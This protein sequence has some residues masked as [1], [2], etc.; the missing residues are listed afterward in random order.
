MNVGFQASDGGTYPMTWGQKAIWKPVKWYGDASSFFNIPVAIDLPGDP[1]PGRDA[2]VAALRTLVERHQ[3]LRS[4][5]FDGPDGPA[6]QIERSGTF[7]IQLA[8]STPAGSR[9]RA[10]ALAT[11]LAAPC[12]DFK[13]E[14]SLRTALVSVDG[15]P[16]H[17]VFVVSHVA[18]D[19]GGFMALV[20]DFLALLG[21][22]PGGTSSEPPGERPA[23][24]SK[25]WQPADQVLSEQSK[26]GVRRSGAAVDYWRK[27]LTRIPPS[28]FGSEGGPAAEPRWHRLRMDSPAMAAAAIRVA[29]DCQISL[30]SAVLTGTALALATLTSQDITVMQLIVS[31]RY[32]DQMRSMVG[33]AAQDGLLVVDYPDV[34]LAEAARA[35]HRAARTGYFYGYYDPPAVDELRDR[36]AA[37]R[38]VQFDLTSYFNDLTPLIGAPTELPDP[39]PTEAEA[40]ELLAQTTIVTEATFGTQDCK[41]F[42]EAECGPAISRVHLLIDTAYVPPPLAETVL[43]GM[44]TILFETA[45]G[46]AT[47]AGIPAL[48]GIKPAGNR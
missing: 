45:F 18:A 48:T 25:A 38:G 1:P 13:A 33:A 21:E 39:P 43:R 40:R 31:N 28:M 4:Y 23:D 10:D 12:F 8:E 30:P 46:D 32:D 44:E 36:L 47:V 22:A 3:S 29:I 2:V 37:K 5:Y 19:G 16:R 6:Q 17:A 27:Q 14:W 9:A 41:F 24:E 11:E 26:R 7:G 34:P 42:V 35:T 15:I 20:N